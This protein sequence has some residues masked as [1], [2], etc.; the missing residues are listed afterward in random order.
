MSIQ[1]NNSIWTSKYCPTKLNEY[2]ISNTQ[3]TCVNE[4]ITDLI[5]NVDGA[6][7]F[8]ILNGSPGVG[9]TTLAHLILEKHG[10][11]IIECNASD[12][13][14]KKNI[15]DALGGISKISVC[16]DNNNNFKHTALILDEIDGLC[17]A[18]DSSGVQEIIDI[19]IS[20]NHKRKLIKWV[21]PVICTTNN[22]KDKKIKNLLKYSI[23]LNIDKPSQKNCIK[24]INK[25]TTEEKFNVSEQIIYNIITTAN[26]DYRQIILLLYQHYNELNTLHNNAIITSIQEQH[27]DIKQNYDT[28]EKTD[29]KTDENTDENTNNYSIDY[30]YDIEIIKQ[31]NNIGNSALDKINFFITHYVSLDTLRF[32][33]SGDSIIFF[34]NFYYNI[35][36]IIYKIQD[37]QPSN[38]KNTRNS[39]LQ[40]YKILYTIYNIIS[41]ADCINNKIFIDRHW[42]LSVYFDIFSIAIPT[43][44]LYTL[45]IKQHTYKN[46]DKLTNKAIEITP[47][48]K[49]PIIKKKIHTSII[50]NVIDVLEINKQCNTNIYVKDFVLS[51][52]SE[53]NYMRQEQC[54]HKKHINIDYMHTYENNITNIYYNIKRFQHINSVNSVNSVSNNKSNNK[55][56]NNRNRKKTTTD[57]QNTNTNIIDKNK[58]VISKTYVKIVNKIDELQRILL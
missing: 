45:N 23:V 12:T 5:H 30:S 36:S 22:I 44:I 11:E 31:I 38:T 47:Q 21:C 53:Y 13:R 19:I 32:I 18:S 16:V 8:L 41:S 3:L 52:H 27:M 37:K 2:Y 48:T 55:S 29:D 49:K 26:G 20:K 24:I 17:G 33:C 28:N 35:I 39:L 1:N 15:Q 4:W 58:Y 25:I 54:A 9:K 46:N 57:S 6:K 7:P 50:P 43:K 14:S 42:D 40:Y 10:Y 51:H 56:N 34:M